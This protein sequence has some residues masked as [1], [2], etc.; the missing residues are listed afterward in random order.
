MVSWYVIFTSLVCHVFTSGYIF[1]SCFDFGLD[2]PT[3]YA[4]LS[5]RGPGTMQ[6][7]GPVN[8]SASWVDLT[9]LDRIGV[10]KLELAIHDR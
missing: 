10:Y 1:Q 7:A 6:W 9:G 8:V 4:V 3:C 5:A 2:R